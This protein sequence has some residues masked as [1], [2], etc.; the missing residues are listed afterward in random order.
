MAFIAPKPKDA[1]PMVEGKKCYASRAARDINMLHA[2]HCNDTTCD[3]IILIL[4]LHSQRCAHAC[5]CFGHVI[6]PAA[7][8]C[9]VAY[10]EFFKSIK[11][12]VK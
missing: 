11:F 7:L 12:R 2:L 6:E 5:A 4:D 10:R 1:C 8:R 3:I 9:N